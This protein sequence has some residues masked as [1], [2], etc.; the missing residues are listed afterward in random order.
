M[1]LDNILIRQS[2]I[3]DKWKHILKYICIS[4]KNLQFE[5]DISL[6]CP[7][8]KSSYCHPC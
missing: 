1:N 6:S 3:I 2:G 5:E 8:K 4:S 7:C